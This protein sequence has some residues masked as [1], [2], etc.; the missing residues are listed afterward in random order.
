[1]A[2]LIALGLGAFFETVGSVQWTAGPQAARSMG[3]G[4]VGGVRKL[5][6]KGKI[7]GVG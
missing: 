2:D 4:V 5:L 3:P 7:G 1:M 6:A